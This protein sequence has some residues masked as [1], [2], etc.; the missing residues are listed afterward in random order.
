MGV[1]W[2]EEKREEFFLLESLKFV[3]ASAP[4]KLDKL[5]SQNWE[6]KN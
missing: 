1:M 3:G 6:D 5:Q 4:V 2:W